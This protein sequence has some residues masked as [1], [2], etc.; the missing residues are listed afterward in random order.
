M[1]HVGDVADGPSRFSRFSGGKIRVLVV[2]N[3]TR[4][5]LFQWR[6]GRFATSF[7]RLLRSL[8]VWSRCVSRG[9]V[10]RFPGFRLDFQGLGRRL[11][12]CFLCGAQWRVVVGAEVWFLAG[13]VLIRWR[14]FCLGR[15]GP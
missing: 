3:K 6:L 13:I 4:V 9:V 15:F 10:F 12:N 11:W 7:W 14:L 1:V 8:R 2:D 5:W